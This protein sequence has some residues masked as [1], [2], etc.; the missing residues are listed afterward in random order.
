MIKVEKDFTNV[1]TL[2]KKKNRKDAFSKNISDGKYTDEKNW[3]KGGSIQ[4]K[5]NKIYNF[6][7]AYCEDS[8]L[9]SPKHIEHYRPKDIYY[10]LA[11]SWDNLLLCCGSCNS[12]KSANFETN[13]S[14]V[15]YTNE[16]YEN[17]HNLSDDYNKLEEPMFI[18]P[19]KEDVIN[20][21]FFDKN[22][23]ILSDN[24]RVNYTIETCNLNREE[25]RKLREEILENFINSINKHYEFFIKYKDITRFIPDIENFINDCNKIKK[26][27]SFKY[28]ILNNPEIFLRIK[29][30]KRL[31]SL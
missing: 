16:S 11:Y 17:I 13:K 8:L 20:N 7:C 31:L 18:N 1:P 19:E 26:F 30:S 15:I 21:L 28:F 23:Q 2:L 10:W 9:N 12:S 24:E 22:S 27:Y 3:Y 29:K 6:K 14:K 25:L 4:K 5:L